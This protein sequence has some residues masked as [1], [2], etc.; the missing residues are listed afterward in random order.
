MKDQI[1]FLT[2][3]IR[4]LT[5]FLVSVT[6]VVLLVDI[7]FPSAGLPIVENIG[8]LVEGISSDGLAGLVALLLFFMLYRQNQ[9]AGQSSPPSG[10]GSQNY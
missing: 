4:T 5:D 6:I 10:G 1:Q 8:A 9:A 3:I 2:G 7:L